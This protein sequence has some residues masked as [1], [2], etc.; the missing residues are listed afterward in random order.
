MLLL[1]DIQY[2]LFI[3]VR[4][5]FFSLGLQIYAYNWAR[6]SS[7]SRLNHK[8]ICESEKNDK[9]IDKTRQSNVVS[10]CYQPKLFVVGVALKSPAAG[11]LEDRERSD[12]QDLARAL[13]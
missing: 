6:H 3:A 9:I 4:P 7:D 1:S 12:V 10:L 2:C 8:V 11:S 13:T 5:V